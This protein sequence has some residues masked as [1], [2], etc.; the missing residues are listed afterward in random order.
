M[1]AL[2]VATFSHERKTMY[3]VSCL[4]NNIFLIVLQVIMSMEILLCLLKKKIAKIVLLLVFN[5]IYRNEY[6]LVFIYIIYE[7]KH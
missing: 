5:S 7:K 2:K 3:S 4:T 6:L 1:S